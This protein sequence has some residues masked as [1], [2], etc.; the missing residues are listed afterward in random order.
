MRTMAIGEF[1]AKCLG[2]MAEMNVTGQPVLVTKR[3]KPFARVSLPEE[4]APQESPESIFGFMR[5]MGTITGDIVSSEYTD[6][7]WDRMFNEKWD[8]FEQEVAE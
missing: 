3:G 7:E 1:K 6:E 5:G 4:Q 8:R 2:V